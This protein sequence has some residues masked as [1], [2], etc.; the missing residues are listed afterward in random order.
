MGKTC[1]RSRRNSLCQCYGILRA[2]W[3]SGK[4][5]LEREI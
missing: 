5:G 3:S 2:W 4:A 1:G